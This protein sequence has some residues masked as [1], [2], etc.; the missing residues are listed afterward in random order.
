MATASKRVAPLTRIGATA[1]PVGVERDEVGGARVLPTA[2]TPGSPQ[3]DM[4]S[5]QRASCVA[6]RER[7]A[8]GEGGRRPPA[9]T[10]SSYVA[11]RHHVPGI[12][13]SA[14]ALSCMR[15]PTGG[16]AALC[17]RAGLRSTRSG[18]AGKRGP[19]AGRGKRPAGANAVA[20]CSAPIDASAAPAWC[21]MLPSGESRTL[22]FS[23]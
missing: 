5:G 20:S 16:A 13:P 7:R 3:G 14:F 9:C 18:P 22:T 21:R 6:G 10:S 15:A 23:C 19:S 8:E 4:G 11:V 1:G 17:S 12:E 2:P